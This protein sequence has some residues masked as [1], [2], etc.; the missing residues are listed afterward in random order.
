[1]IPIAD[2]FVQ[3]PTCMELRHKKTAY[4]ETQMESRL[5]VRLGKIRA[6][7]LGLK[8]SLVLSNALEVWAPK[9]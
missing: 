4:G 5:R 7:L 1:M 9:L 6:D 8:A 3:I 2:S